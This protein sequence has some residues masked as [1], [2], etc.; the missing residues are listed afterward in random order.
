[1]CEPIWYT[2]GESFS[3]FA[4]KMMHLRDVDG[5]QG[6]G[7]V[8]L[9]A[10]SEGPAQGNGGG[11]SLRSR[12][13]EAMNFDSCFWGNQGLTERHLVAG[14]VDGQRGDVRAA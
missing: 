7:E 11:A 13:R 2:C 14:A 3:H 5:E 8:V 9:F 4:L 10:L 6:R 12:V 1:M